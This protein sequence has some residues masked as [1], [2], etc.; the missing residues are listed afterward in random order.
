[1]RWRKPPSIWPSRRRRRIPPIFSLGM[2]TAGC[3]VATPTWQLSG[4]PSADAS[5]SWQLVDG[6]SRVL[7]Y[8]Q[9]GRFHHLAKTYVAGPALF[10]SM[11]SIRADD[12]D[13]GAPDRPRYRGCRD[14]DSQ[15]K[16]STLFNGTL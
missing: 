6:R 10:P 7:G 9:T 14:T 12:L 3:P 5:R 15:S 16:S 11:G 1:M 13:A 2:V 8:G 4:T